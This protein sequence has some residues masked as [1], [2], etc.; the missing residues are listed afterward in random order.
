MW[1]ED[2]VLILNVNEKRQRTD[3]RYTQGIQEKGVDKMGILIRDE[4]LGTTW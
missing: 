1:N 3:G 2:I 4:K